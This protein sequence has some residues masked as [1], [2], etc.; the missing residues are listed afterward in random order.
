MSK[1][2]NP[3]HEEVQKKRDLEQHEVKQV[4]EFLQ[5][6]G[7]LIGAGVVAAAVAVLVSRGL[8]A[9]KAA[10]IAEA[11]QMLTAAQTPQQL[12]EL[13]N[14]YKSTPTAPV[15]LLSLAKT[16]FNQGDIAQART[17]YERF[18]D[19]YK[20]SALRPIATFGL[21]HCTEAEGRFSDAVNEFKDFL[22]ANPDHYL[23]SPAVLAVARCQRKAGQADAA[24]ITLEDFLAENVDSQWAGLAEA[25]LELLSK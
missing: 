22:A 17:H 24:R 16:L 11:E 6:Y 9:S 2:D 20:N 7:K 12:E 14:D 8:A 10:K 25:S 19:D 3:K 5:R 4:L 15:A 13:V 1:N 18:L 21:A 23:E